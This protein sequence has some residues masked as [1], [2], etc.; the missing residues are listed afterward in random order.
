MF[1]ALLDSTDE[2]L[3]QLEELIQSLDEPS[4]RKPLSI[5]NG[6]SIGEHIRHSLEFFLA[7]LSAAELGSVCYDRRERDPRIQSDPA[8]AVDTVAQ[9]RKGLKEID[10]TSEGNEIKLHVDWLEG[11]ALPSTLSREL[12]YVQ[13]HLLHHSALIKTG[14][15]HGLENPTSRQIRD[16]EKFGVAPSTLAYQSGLRH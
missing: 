3:A 9:I 2:M 13:D 7:Y 4:Y 14:L 8:F 5:L 6:A 16:M 10:A 12:H 11:D 15:L 1:Q